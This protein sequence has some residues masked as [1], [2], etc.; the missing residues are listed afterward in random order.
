MMLLVSGAT[1][2]MRRCADNPHLGRLVVPR[3]QNAPAALPA[4][5]PW[6]MDNGA[7]TG[8]DADLYEKAAKRWAPLRDNCLFITLPDVVG[9]AEKTMALFE[10]M[11]GRV[12]GWGYPAELHALV[13]QDGLEDMQVPWPN[14]GTLFIGGT[15]AFK[16]GAG[17]ERLVREAK[18]RDKRVH[19]GRVNTM[20]RVRHFSLMA[21][22]TID[23]SKFSMYPDTYIPRFLKHLSAEKKQGQLFAVQET[24]HGP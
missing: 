3:D 7:Y 9:D 10:M 1:E 24:A 4:S 18:A 11:Q 12:R 5:M 19:V 6:G 21:V 15:T 2:T 20:R 16:M 23:G 22:D 8:F 13:A 14:F 17:A